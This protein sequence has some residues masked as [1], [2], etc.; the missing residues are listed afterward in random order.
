MGFFGDLFGGTDSKIKTKK[1]N[2]WMPEQEDFYRMMLGQGLGYDIGQSER[3]ARRGSPWNFESW[4]RTPTEQETGFGDW[5]QNYPQWAGEAVNKAFDPQYI[6]DVYKNSIMPEFEANVLP[7]VKEQYAG[8]G[9]WSNARAR[10]VSDAYGNIA[11]QEAEDISGF[12]GMRKKS[13]FDLLSREP[14]MQQMGAQW[15]RYLKDLGDPWTSPRWQEAI[16]LLGLSPW[17]IVGGMTGAQPGLLSS[18][19]GVAGR[20]LGTWATGGFGGGGG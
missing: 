7:Q 3:S 13:L 19:A 14:D 20:A 1:I 8:P 11:R 17:Q 2:Q 18:F 6:K 15:S 10:G 9:Y 4:G 12:E 16:K 5:L